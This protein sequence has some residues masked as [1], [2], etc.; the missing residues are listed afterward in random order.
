[1]NK[2]KRAFINPQQAPPAPARQS[3][4]DDAS[5]VAE[6]NAQ[7]KVGGIIRYRKYKPIIVAI[8]LYQVLKRLV[9][10]H[11]IIPRSVTGGGRLGCLPIG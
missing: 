6:P 1:M 7:S 5:H 3:L 4:L 9:L 11:L 10:S 2:I 8:E